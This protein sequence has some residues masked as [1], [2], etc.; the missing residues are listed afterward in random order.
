MNIYLGKK[1]PHVRD[2]GH[3]TKRNT[4]DFWHAVD[5]RRGRPAWSLF[6][7]QRSRRPW[8]K[9]W[10]RH[11]G[12]IR[13]ITRLR[14]EN[15]KRTPDMDEEED[16]WTAEFPAERIQEEPGRGS[17]QRSIGAVAKAIGPRTGYSG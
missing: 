9:A 16:A 7:M 3:T 6:V 12:Q 15:R 4:R 10:D 14:K 1:E 17:Q 8:L 13:S 11:H 2:L 5:Q